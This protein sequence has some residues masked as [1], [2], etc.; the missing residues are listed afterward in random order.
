LARLS[1]AL[2]DAAFREAVRR[3]D[4][5]EVILQHARRFDEQDQEKKAGGATESK[6]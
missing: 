3:Q 2:R 1:Y 5:P 4:P 6:E